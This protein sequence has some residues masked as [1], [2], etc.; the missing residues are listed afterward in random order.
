MENKPQTRAVIVHQLVQDAGHHAAR[1][2]LEV[3]ELFDRHR[4]IGFAAHV[5]A[6]GHARCGG[7]SG[8]LFRAVKGEATAHGDERDG[9]DNNK[10]QVAFHSRSRKGKRLARECQHFVEGGIKPVSFSVEEQ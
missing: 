2:T 8:Q 3:A 1:R 4:R 6:A 5:G 7:R 9:H 10:W